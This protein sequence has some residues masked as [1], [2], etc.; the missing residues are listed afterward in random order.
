MISVKFTKSFGNGVVLNGEI[1][2][3]NEKELQSAFDWIMEENAKIIHLLHWVF[4]KLKLLPS[5][6]FVSIVVK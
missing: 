3:K 1:S 4:K 6:G 2:C 5:R